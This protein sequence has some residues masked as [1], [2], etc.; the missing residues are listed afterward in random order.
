MSLKSLI[1]QLD[2][3]AESFNSAPHFRARVHFAEHI[4]DALDDISKELEATIAAPHHERRKRETESR[5][6]RNLQLVL[7]EDHRDEPSSP[8]SP[9]RFREKTLVQA[10]RVLLGDHGQL[11]GK[12]IEDLLK[13]GGYETTAEHFQSSMAVAFKRDGGFENVGGNLWRLRAPSPDR[14][15][16]DAVPGSPNGAVHER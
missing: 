4:Y 6:H 12:A 10:A 8:P 3:F 7:P 13:A 1:Q 11:H 9:A 16:S 2:A 15:I 14:K 5:A